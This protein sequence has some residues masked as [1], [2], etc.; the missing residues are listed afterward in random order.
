[1]L[2]KWQHDNQA[3]Q[4]VFSCDS[5]LTALS[6]EKDTTFPSYCQL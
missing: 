1:M 2:P 3:G 6:I 4:Q 5:S